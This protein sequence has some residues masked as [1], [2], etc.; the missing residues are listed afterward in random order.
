MDDMPHGVLKRNGSSQAIICASIGFALALGLL[1]PFGISRPDT[2]FD[3]QFIVPFLSSS[4]VLFL[5]SYI[6][7]GVAGPLV[8]R[9]RDNRVRMGLIGVCLAWVCV[10]LTPLIGC[11][12]NVLMQS[13]IWNWGQL[14][15]NFSDFVFKPTFWICFVGSVPAAL[16]GVYFSRRMNRTFSDQ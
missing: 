12:P 1:L 10:L 13:R 8:Y 2:L 14:S 3:P 16:L 7:G 6:L 15:R 9:V 5:S 11:L 4:I